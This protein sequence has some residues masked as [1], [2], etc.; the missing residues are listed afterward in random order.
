MKIKTNWLSK[1]LKSWIIRLSPNKKTTHRLTVACMS[2]TD[3]ILKFKGTILH[4]NTRLLGTKNIIQQMN[5]YTSP[6]TCSRR[7]RICHNRTLNRMNFKEFEMS[8]IITKVWMLRPNGLEM[9]PNSVSWK[10]GSCWESS[11]RAEMTW[12]QNNSL[13]NW[14]VWCIRFSGERNLTYG[15]FPMKSS[16]LDST[17]VWLNLWKMG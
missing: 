16:Q 2:F 8:S 9:P 15:S 11:S 5:S 17:V 10:L 13:C 1:A 6:L 12:G 3:K 4:L 14:L 7:K